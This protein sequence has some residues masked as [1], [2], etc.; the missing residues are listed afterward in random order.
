MFISVYVEVNVDVIYPAGSIFHVLN[1][2]SYVGEFFISTSPESLLGRDGA[3]P[4][5][6]EKAL[7]TALLSMMVA[8]K[9]RTPKNAQAPNKTKINVILPI[10]SP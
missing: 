10:S 1:L 9:L 5:D 8:T 4:F 2:G 7:Y 6:S 3:G